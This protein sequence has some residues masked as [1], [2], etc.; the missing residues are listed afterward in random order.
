MNARDR[1]KRIKPLVYQQEGFRS[2]QLQVV[3]GDS[4]LELRI[5]GKLLPTA[6]E[7]NGEHFSTPFCPYRTYGDLISLG[8]AVIRSGN[9]TGV[10][11]GV[12]S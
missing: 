10:D 9:W 8:K 11:H 7:P 2:H 12:N 3:D 4:Q 6:A 1:V 5:D